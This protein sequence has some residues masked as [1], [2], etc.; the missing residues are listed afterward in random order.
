M[1]TNKL[2]HT[3]HRFTTLL[4]NQNQNLNPIKIN[5]KG[6]N[7]MKKFTKI[8]QQLKLLKIKNPR[9]KFIKL[10][11]III[12]ATLITR[13]SLIH[14]VH[15][16]DYTAYMQKEEES[17]LV[18]RAQTRGSIYDRNGKELVTN[19][20][21]LSIVYRYDAKISVDQM[22]NT[23]FILA[24]MI[25]IDTKK[26]SSS[27][28]KDLY[29]RLHTD[30]ERVDITEADLESLTD[31][32]KQAQIIFNKMS[33]AY[34]G[35]ENTLKFDANDVEIAQVVENL[36]KLS[37]VDVVTQ[38]TREYPDDLG[39]HDIV[40][41]VSKGDAN[42]PAD[43]FTKYMDAGYS[44][45]DRI[46]LS[47]VERQYEDLLRGH[48]SLH[49]ISPTGEI[50]EL[51]E[52][53][54]GADLM[55]TI[56]TE[57]SD[58]IDDIL[59]RRMKNAKANRPGAKYLREGYVV[60][61]V[62]DT[63]EILSLNGKI[64]DDDGKFT[65]HSLGTLYNSYTMGSVVKG[66]T[67]LT[68]YEHGVTNFGDVI[69]DRPMIFSD[70]TEKASWTTLGPVND[71]QALRSSSNVYFMQQAIRMGGGIYYPE[72]YLNVNLDTIYDHRTSFAQ[73][74]LGSRTGVDLPGEEIGLR[75]QDKSIAKLLDFVIGQSDTYTTLQLAGYVATIANGGN[76]YALQLLK[77]ASISISDDEKL[78]IYSFK[79]D[80]LNQID[81]PSEAFD[82]VQEGFR[83]VLQTAGGTGYSQFKN[84]RYSPAGKTGTA[85]EFVRDEDGN[86]M[87][88]WYGRL[89]EVNHITFVGY[90]PH[91][92]PEIALA[93]VFPQSELPKE[94]NPIALEVANEIINEY[95]EMEKSRAS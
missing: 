63:G 33:E 7:I 27:D 6:G 9:I 23:A 32:E 82:R 51:H 3:T 87:F 41:R 58:R 34:F 29:Q 73:Y 35:G 76:R 94:K 15:S 70:G 72:A 25:E 74:G 2:A 79:P 83:Q 20:P 81:L 67:L 44:V 31:I 57:L 60:V 88:D 68:G 1:K 47:S 77:E 46:G 36:D 42:F 18:K 26:I 5:P 95:F 93:V 69:D 92:N 10:I 54:Q 66:A 78:L 16:A 17:V 64:L 49:E 50:T 52:G 89:I 56:D 22:Y 24:E 37:G 38:A 84:S 61:V 62:P 91:R 80:L 55:L 43:N 45:N 86:L 39:H 30:V 19:I 90:A 12:V 53:T 85:E 75:N 11:H 28:L 71:I 4:N 40:G 48:K 59:E 13:I 65:D 8:R 21:I 14:H